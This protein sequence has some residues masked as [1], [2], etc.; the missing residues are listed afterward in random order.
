M[1]PSWSI[2]LSTESFER[3]CQHLRSFGEGY[4]RRHFGGS[5]NQADAEDVVAEVLF[6]I[7]RKL[8][9]GQTFENPRAVFQVSLRN[10]GIDALRSREIRPTVKLE[11]AAELAA[12]TPGPVELAS[13][14]EDATRFQ[15]VLGRMRPNYREAILLR[16]GLG[17]TVPEIA[18]RLGISLPAAKK[19]V[20]RA[21]DQARKRL[22][23]I[24]GAEFCE[25]MRDQV[26]RLEF[27][28]HACDRVSD[29]EILKTH[30]SHC[31]G[32]RSFLLKLRRT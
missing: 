17:M 26:R 30:I 32:C 2:R 4:L 25:Q 15:E 29:L 3:E 18:R 1:Q 28:G 9:S 8:A 27:E 24:E 7:H 5:L 6:R 11:A 10:A 13:T 23:S 31:G 21:T 16:F 19:L 22:T 14:Q 20:L 12:S